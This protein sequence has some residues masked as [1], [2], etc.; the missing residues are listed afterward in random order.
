[1][2]YALLYESADDVRTKAPLHFAEH[3]A[4][5]RAYQ[6]DGTLLMVGP[7]SNPDDGAMAIFTTREAAEAFAASDPFVLNGVVKSWRVAEWMEA[8][9]P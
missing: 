2:K 1:M 9:A 4:H 8:I 5:W 7:F 3:R 6:D